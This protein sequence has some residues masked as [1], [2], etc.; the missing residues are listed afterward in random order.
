MIAPNSSNPEDQKY[1]CFQHP[2]AVAFWACQRCGGFICKECE[3]RPRSEAPPLCPNCWQLR[4]KAVSANRSKESKGLRLAGLIIGVV[5]LI[6]PLVIIVSLIVNI[7]ALNKNN[8]NKDARRWM[9]VAGIVF[10]ICATII[11][12]AVFGFAIAR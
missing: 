4:E 5:S 1:F 10:T 7:K 2:G 12:I 3:R 6:S 8:Q 9:N 11:W